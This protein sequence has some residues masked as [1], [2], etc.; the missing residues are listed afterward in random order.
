MSEQKQQL[1]LI[2]NHLVKK[3]N[4]TLFKYTVHLE[5]GVF[6]GDLSDTLKCLQ[7]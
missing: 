5:F 4:P 7:F 6:F 1:G 3:K 2:K